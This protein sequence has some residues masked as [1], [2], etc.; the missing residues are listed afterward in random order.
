MNSSSS[1]TYSQLTANDHRHGQNIFIY[2]LNVERMSPQS[3]E[4]VPEQFMECVCHEHY[5]NTLGIFWEPTIVSWIV[6]LPLCHYDVLADEVW[7]IEH[8]WDQT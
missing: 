8:G 4:N 7:S 3:T 5:W 2:K 1:N 6:S